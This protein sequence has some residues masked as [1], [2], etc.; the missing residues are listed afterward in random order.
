MSWQTDSSDIDR[1]KASYDRNQ[2]LRRDHCLHLFKGS[3]KMDDMD[4][5]IQ[6]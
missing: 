4:F 3:L 1:T 2:E 6:S 5:P